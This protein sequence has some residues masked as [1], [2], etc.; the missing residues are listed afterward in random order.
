MVL[1][2]PPLRQTL[3]EGE[4]LPR[5]HHCTILFTKPCIG[6]TQNTREPSAR[7]SKV[8]FKNLST[9]NARSWRDGEDEIRH[10]GRMIHMRTT[11]GAMNKKVR[12]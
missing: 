11:K 10:R 3:P 5:E 7:I 12:E 8:L 9:F 2:E 4:V 6:R 1:V